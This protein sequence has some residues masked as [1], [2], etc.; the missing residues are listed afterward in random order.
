M[1][2]FHKLTPDETFIFHF[3]HDGI[4][5]LVAT[6]PKMKFRWENRVFSKKPSTRRAVTAAIVVFGGV[7]YVGTAP[8]SWQDQF[9]RKIGYRMALGRALRQA[10]RMY[11]ALGHHNSNDKYPYAVGEERLLRDGQAS[12]TQKFQWAKELLKEKYKLS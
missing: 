6:E 12:R 10:G 8:C 1:R 9:N 11:E 5:R 3:R 4:R 7:A 2:A